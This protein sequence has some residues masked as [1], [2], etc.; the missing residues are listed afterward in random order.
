MSNQESFESPSHAAEGAPPNPVMASRPAPSRWGWGHW[1]ATLTLA[2]LLFETLTGLLIT[3][4]PFHAAIQWSVL[5]HT[6]VGAVLLLPVAWYC[7]RHVADY[8][9]YAASHITVLGWVAL[10]ALAVVS[11]S[12]VVLT[13]QAVVGVRTTAFWRQVHLVSTL[14]MLAGLAPHLVASALRQRK[15][16][17]VP[18]LA[19][20]AIRAT[21]LAGMGVAAC[22]GL[23]LIYSGTRYVNQF[24]EDYSFLYGTNRPFAPS[25]AK[26]DTGGAFDARSLAGSHS[27]GTAGCH[28]QIL[29]EWEP[30]AHRYAAMDKIFLGI[31]NVMAQQNGPESTRYC[32]GCHDPISLFSGTKNIFVENLTGLHGYQEGVSCLACHAIRETDIKGNANYTVTQPAEYLWQ[33]ATNGPARLL[34]DFL[35]RSYPAEHNK[36]AKRSFKKPEYCAACHK[37][38][39]DAEVNRVGWVQLQN[40]YDNWAASHWNK[41]GDPRKTIECRECHMPLVDSRDPAAGDALDYNRHARDGKH[42]SHRFLGAN[43]IIPT[44]Q[45]DEL[46]GWKR[47][48][49]LTEQWLR[50]EFAVPEIADKW[51]HGPIVKL[52]ASAPASVAPGEPIPLRVVMASNKVGHDFPTGPLDIIQSWLDITVTD[53]AGQVVW[54]SG[55]RDEKNFLQPGTFLFKA[56][57]VDQHGNLIDRHNLWEMVGVRFR[58]ALFPGYS[59]TVNFTIPCSGAV[60]ASEAEP[61]AGG[62]ETLEVPA[63]AVPAPAQAGEYRIAVTL[64]YRKVDQFLLNYLLGETNT[65]TSPVTE[66]ARTE[67]KVKVAP[68]LP[69]AAAPQAAAGAAQDAEPAANPETADQPRRIPQL[70]GPVAAQAAEVHSARKP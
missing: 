60:A 37:Q 15:T 21:V 67:L 43:T 24:P 46:P 2:A 57:P 11:A 45:D 36:L 66:I 65:L 9:T 8:R 7:A 53:D 44:F 16:A 42:R 5:L 19:R 39:I 29:E 62:A 69:A 34:R 27:C 55:K 13:V 63:P 17:P 41:K 6:A 32:G 33:W 52:A 50:G 70:A 54:T 47:H 68:A 12:G 3:L 28:E 26:T 20:S 40:Q 23:A 14:V 56:E 22:F 25:L 64:Q 18:G 31:Q 38:F 35:I 48:L 10:A 30:S 61:P 51:A 58:R 59:D 4:A 49:E 1:L